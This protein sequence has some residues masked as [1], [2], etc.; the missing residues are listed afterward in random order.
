MVKGAR[1]RLGHTSN[2]VVEVVEDVRPDV[3][4]F[5]YRDDAGRTHTMTWWADSKI[6]LVGTLPEVEPEKHD[7]LIEA[8]WHTGAPG[9]GPV[10]TA[11]CVH[12]THDEV[13]QKIA[14]PHWAGRVR[15]VY[16]DVSTEF[17]LEVRS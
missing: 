13:Q 11:K 15:A 6:E 8:V 12:A 17:D 7:Y 3:V 16:R 4:C 9:S 5:S 2:T 1:F 14:A 10:H